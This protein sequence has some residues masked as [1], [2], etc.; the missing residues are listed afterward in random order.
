MSD[1][2]TLT[3]PG[4]PIPLERAARIGQG[5]R[6]YLPAKSVE[7]RQRVQAAWMQSGRPDMGDA[8]LAV[9]ARFYLARPASHYGTGRNAHTIKARYLDAIPLGDIDNMCKA[10][11]DSL[12]TLAFT[13]D[14][15][16]VCLAAIHK[17][18]APQ[19]QARTVIDLWAAR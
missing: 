10:V 4:A 15:Q 18:W 14:R 17:T 9:S 16:V 1:V 13:D 5:G 2:V 11:L 8:P 3:V 6:H 12:G 7:Y 19:D